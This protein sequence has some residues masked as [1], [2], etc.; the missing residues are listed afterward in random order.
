MQKLSI[1]RLLAMGLVTSVIVIS[2]GTAAAQD[3]K[4]LRIGT[5]TTDG[6]KSYYSVRCSNDQP[7]SITVD[8]TARKTCASALGGKPRCKKK[9]SLK[10]AGEYACAAP[11]K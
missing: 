2:A 11:S 7:G 10:R 3:S 5:S 8:H 9:W 6:D 4:V 1:K